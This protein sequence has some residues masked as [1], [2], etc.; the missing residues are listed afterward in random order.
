MSITS[1]EVNF[2]VFRYLQ[3]AGF[4]HA[5]FTF[6][7]EAMVHKTAPNINGND[8]PPGMLVSLVQKGLQFIELE[9]NLNADGSMDEATTSDFAL[10]R[11]E[12][13]LTKDVDALREDLRERRQVKQRQESLSLA[14][15]GGGANKKH[16]G[17][18]GN[19]KGANGVKD[20]NAKDDGAPSP[21]DEDGPDGGKAKG[22]AAPEAELIPDEDVTTL[23]GHTSEVF[24]CAWS[25][26]APLLASGSGDATARIWRDDPSCV[27]DNVI[28]P[29]EPIVLRHWSPD[30]AHDRDWLASGSGKDGSGKRGQAAAKGSDG[31]G[32]G[33][34]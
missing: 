26:N 24:I 11:P 9:A 6:G 13:L 34:G 27:Q 1:D 2:L 33:S 32:I 3:E 18:A 31:G 16:K 8:V 22:D 7:Y 20:E 12:E 28:G 4:R 19:G 21:M 25:P 5:S 23:V 17:A 29:N 14:R 10:L 30:G 15:D